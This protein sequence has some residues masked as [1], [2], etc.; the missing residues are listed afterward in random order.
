LLTLR[1]REVTR[2]GSFVER[3]RDHRPVVA[4]RRPVEAWMSRP[5][6]TTI[7]YRTRHD[8]VIVWLLDSEVRPK[9]SGD[10]ARPE[11]GGREDAFAT[12]LTC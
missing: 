2:D 12:D 10:D 3:A 6:G 1:A 5:I 8:E 9:R 11:A 4:A 7:G